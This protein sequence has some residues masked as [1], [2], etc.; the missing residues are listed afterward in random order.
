MSQFR[1]AYSPPV[2][3]AKAFHVDQVDK[4]TGEITRI[5]MKGRTKQAHKDECDINN[6]L[7]RYRKSG[8]ID[9][10]NRYQG[11]YGDVSTAE[12]FQTSV[13]R[14]MEANAMFMSLPAEIRRRFDNDPAAFLDFMLDPEKIEQQRELG[15]V[16]PE[17]PPVAPVAPEPDPEPAPEPAPVPKK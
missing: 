2:R 4:E 7:T 14:V 3:V 1:T 6:I 15:L 11:R 5:P 12:D 8:L 9:H 16:P 17:N 10:V 13:N